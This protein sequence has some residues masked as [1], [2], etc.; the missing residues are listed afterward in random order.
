MKHSSG[1]MDAIELEADP[2]G[3]LRAPW[4]LLAESLK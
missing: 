3:A 2:Q 4:S 1:S